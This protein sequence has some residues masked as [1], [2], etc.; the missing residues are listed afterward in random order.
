MTGDDSFKRRECGCARDA[1][2]AKA[3]AA[4]QHRIRAR[5]ISVDRI[6]TQRQVVM[7]QLVL[8][9]STSNTYRDVA[10]RRRSPPSR[11]I[12]VSWYLAIAFPAAERRRRGPSQEKIRAAIL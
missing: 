8:L 7:I 3:A 6:M 12:L 9:H 1:V 11:F 4:F 10:I 2:A 5:T